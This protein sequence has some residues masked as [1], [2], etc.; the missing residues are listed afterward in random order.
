MNYNNVADSYLKLNRLEEARATATEAQ[1]KGFDS[2]TLRF[3][4][5]NIAFLQN[6]AAGMAQQVAW[7]TGKRGVEDVLLA[8]EADTAAYA[9]RLTQARE[10][11]RQ[12]VASALQ[13]G[14][15][16]VAATYEADAASREV[17]FGNAAQTR[18]RATA[19][20]ALSTGRQV[21]YE[22][23]LALALAGDAGG[24]QAIAGDL[25]KRFPEY[26]VIQFK[27]LPTVH[28]QLALSRND[29]S[30]AID[31]LQP[32][33]PYE[34]GLGD[35]LRVVYVRGQAHLAAHQGSEAAAEFQ[36]IL[37]HRG[38]V[39][40]QPIGALARLALG[41]AYALQG[42]SAKARAAYQDFLTLW[43]DADPDIP[44][45]VEAKKEY[46]NL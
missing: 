30:K 33:A 26:T 39:L 41:R 20:L 21:Q 4:L 6:D 42:E 12:A 40:N 17:L 24:A 28:A 7:A 1:A 5:Y 15:K 46:A 43:K 31:L 44:I 45:F 35:S 10:F 38:I 23:A 16:E 14:E 11:S 27:Y 13:A 29:Y 36:K 19:A 25:A 34:L 18:Q 22:A 3:N 37:D 32:A 9:G 8:N 2:S